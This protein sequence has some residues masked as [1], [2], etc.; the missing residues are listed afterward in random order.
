MSFPIIQFSKTGYSYFLSSHAQ[1]FI[2]KTARPLKIPKYRRKYLLPLNNPDSVSVQQAKYM[3][4]EDLV[5]G[6]IVNGQPKAYPLYILSRYHVVNDVVAEKALLISFCEVCSGASAFSPEVNEL[7]KH[8]LTF[9]ICGRKYGTFEICDIET[10]SRWHPFAGKAMEGMLKGT[11]LKRI[12][13][14]YESWKSWR[15]KYPKTLVLNG[16]DNIRNREHSKN[17]QIGDSYLNEGFKKVSNFED[18]RLPTHEF[19]FGLLDSEEKPAAIALKDIG[20]L[21]QFEWNNIHYVIFLENTHHVGVF[22]RKTGDIIRN[23]NL[24][25]SFPF[26]MVDS[27]KNIWNDV[28]EAVA[29]PLKGSKLE[30][31]SGYLTEWYEWVSFKPKSHIIKPSPVSQVPEME[32]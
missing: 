24:H 22:R 12:P 32:K 7:P 25:S 3:R 29:G 21:S 1:K 13:I 31:A 8:F 9:Q 19:V 28:G 10:R 6:L 18:K 27:D 16:S 5:I 4:P 11:S 20:Q 14:Y 2:C 23:F 26:K 17:I 15:F 30:P